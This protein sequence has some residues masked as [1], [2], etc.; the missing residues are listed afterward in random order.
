[1]INLEPLYKVRRRRRMIVSLNEVSD[2]EYEYG[3]IDILT[4]PLPVEGYCVKLGRQE[5]MYSFRKLR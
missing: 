2:D 3:E 5:S 4:F 1:M